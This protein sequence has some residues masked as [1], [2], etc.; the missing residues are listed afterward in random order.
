M[1]LWGIWLTSSPKVRRQPGVCP[2]CRWQSWW[3]EAHQ[4]TRKKQ[5]VAVNERVHFVVLITDCTFTALTFNSSFSGHTIAFSHWETVAHR[6]FAKPQRLN[7]FQPESGGIQRDPSAKNTFAFG[8]LITGLYCEC[9]LK[10]Q[11]NWPVSRL[12]CIIPPFHSPKRIITRLFL[13]KNKMKNRKSLVFAFVWIKVRSSHSQRLLPC[14]NVRVAEQG[15]Q[16]TA[17]F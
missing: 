5:N 16:Q 3:V 17:V 12:A 13:N 7:V 14:D 6:P 2:H 1:L 9:R 10:E 8:G 15:Y 11:L 4:S